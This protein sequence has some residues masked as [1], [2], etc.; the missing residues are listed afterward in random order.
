[1]GTTRKFLRNMDKVSLSN[2]GKATKL[3]K[4]VSA[5]TAMGFVLQPVAAMAQ[6]VTDIKPVN[7]GANVETNGKVT[8]VWA[9][10]VVN[11][12]ALN[13]FKKFDVG[14]ND[15]ANMYFHEQGKTAEANNLVNM[16]GSKININGTVNAI[17]NSKI[18][19]NLYFLSSNGIAVGAG[20]VVN[21]GSL[22][23]MTP[24]DRFMKTAMAAAGTDGV[25]TDATNA[26]INIFDDNYKVDVDTFKN[27]YLL[28][29][30]NRFQNMEVAINKTGTITVNGKINTTDG[31]RMKAAHINI[32][33]DVDA[34]D[35]ATNNSAAQAVLQSGV[36][37]FD[38]LVNLTAEQKRDAGLDG[39][40]TAAVSGDGNIVLTAVANSVNTKDDYAGFMSQNVQGYNSAQATIDIGNAEIKAVT[41]TPAKDGAPVGTIDIS[42]TATLG[43]DNG[44]FLG[45]DIIDTNLAEILGGKISKADAKI[46]ID[47]KLTADTIN[48]AANA[49]NSYE[50]EAT[51]NVGTLKDYAKDGIK[52]LIPGIDGIEDALG[53]E[54]DVSY[55]KLASNAEVT[56]GE[57]AEL[58]ATGNGTLEA[59]PNEDN[60]DSGL[61]EGGALNISAIS[62]LQ[63][64][65]GASSEQEP[66][67][68][69]GNAKAAGRANKQK[70]KNT[71]AKATPNAGIAIV[72]TQNNATV[73]VKGKL[74]AEKGDANVLASAVNNVEA[75]AGVT[76]VADKAEGTDSNYV[77]AAVTIANV[78]NAS[79]VEFAGDKVEAKA[80]GELNVLANAKNEVTTGASAGSDK[81]AL[82]NSAINITDANSSAD[83]IVAGK[84]EANKMNLAANNTVSNEMQAANKLGESK[85]E[86]KS[87]MGQGTL[88][89]FFGHASKKNKKGDKV[90]SIGNYFSAGAAVNI[91]EETNSA[92]V[93]IKRGAQLTA[94]GLE[95]TDKDGN[96]VPNL[97]ISANNVIEDSFM[98]ATSV[99][100]NYTG[101]KGNSSSSG[102]VS[103]GSSGGN[104][105]AMA[106]AAVLD[107]DMDN[108]AQVIIEGSDQGTS[109]PQI[110]GTHVDISAN[111]GF[112]YDRLGSMIDGLKDDYK[113]IID[114]YK[115]SLDGIAEW[116]TALDRVDKY[117][118]NPS[119]DGAMDVAEA[120]Q[121]A[122]DAITLAYVDTVTGVPEDLQTLVE[123]LLKFADISNYTNFYTAAS[124]AGGNALGGKAGGSGSSGQAKLAAT[125][126]INLNSIKNN[127]QVVIGKGAQLEAK[128]KNAKN[129]DVGELNITAKAKQHD[130]ALN[131]KT[132]Y[133]IPTIS[134]TSGGAT[135][136]GG[137][138]GVHDADVNSLIAIGEGASLTAN[139][140]NLKAEN[141]LQHTAITFGGGA[142]T[143]DGI[144]G[145]F[146]YMEGQSNSII[147]VDDEASINAANKL[148][149]D[150]TNNSTISNI[151]FD[152]TSAG[153]S[154]I[155]AA[156][157][158]IDYKVNNI[159][160]VADNDRDAARG[161]D[162]EVS[163]LQTLVQGQLSEE[164]K[165]QLGT[166]A[167]SAGKGTDNKGT[168]T[169]NEVDINAKT[170]GTITGVSVAGV[171]AGA[172]QKNNK[173]T[174]TGFKLP[175]KIAGAGSASVNTISGNT[176]ALLEG[177]EVATTGTNGNVSV[178]AKDE[179]MIGAYSGAA[180]LKK[181]GKQSS[182][183]GFSATLAG[184]IAYN[185][186]KTGVTA[187]I[188]DAAIK[189]A[190]KIS[191][192]AAREGAVVAAG[193]ALGVDTTGQGGGSS[194]TTIN[195]GV[196]ASI[197]EIDNST[198]AVMNNVTTSI[199]GG[200][201]T[202]PA[203]TDI[204]NIAQ[205]KDI[206]IAGGITAQYA[207]GGGIGI[208][209]AVSSLD[210]KNDI[211]SKIIG[212][213]SRLANVGELKAYAASDLVQVGTVLSAGVIQGQNGNAVEAAVANNQLENNVNVTI[214]GGSI[215]AN[216]IDAK[217]YDG[218]IQATTTH[219]KDLSDD[220][221]ETD[222]KD[223]MDEIN[224]VDENGKTHGTN[225]SIEKNKLGESKKDDAGNEQG[226]EG[227]EVKD[228]TADS[229]KGN[230]IISGAASI[231]ANTSTQGKV[232][233]GAAVV[234][235][236]IKNNFTTNITGTTITADT[237]QANAES[238]TLMVGVAAGAAVSTGANAVA[239]LAGS[240][241]VIQLENNT[242]TTI[243]NATITAKELEA[244]ATTKSRLINVAGQ[245]SVS[246]G[247]AAA[248][249][250]TATNVLNNTT[251][252]YIYGSK[253]TGKDGNDNTKLTVEADNNSEA[254]AI[255]VG[256]A[257]Q[258]AQQGAAL[259]GDVAVNK[260]VN[261]TEAIIGKR[262]NGNGNGNII[263]NVDDIDIKAVDNTKLK[264]ISGGVTVST[265]NAGLGG[266]VAYNQ[267]GDASGKQGTVAKL[268]DTVIKTDKATTI[269]VNAEDTSKMLAIAVGAAVQTG[270]S[271]A[272]AQGSAATTI[273]HKNVEAAVSNVDIDKDED[274]HNASLNVNAKS[275]AEA[276]TSADVVAFSTAN[277]AGGA[278]VAVT[279]SQ[280]DTKA[281]ITGGSMNLKSGK[282]QA[283]SKVD[284]I[285]VGIGVAAATGQ[286]GSIAGNVAVNNIGN[287]TTASIDGA[288][289]NASGTIGVLAD[290]KEHIRNYAG[291]LAA[292]V[293]QGYAAGGLSTA[294]NVISGNT[295]ANVS[296]SNITAA[297]DDAG[298]DVTEYAKDSKNNKKLTGLVVNAD[299][300]HEI[301]NVVVTAGA[302]VTAEAAVAASG[303]VTV[304]TI[305]GS[306]VAGIEGTNV[307]SGASNSIANTADVSVRANDNTEIGSHV[308]SAAVA[309]SANAGVSVG[310]A[311]DSNVMNRE[312][313]AQIVGDSSKNT[314]NADKLTVNAFNKHDI[315][316]NAIGIAGAG[317]AYAGVGVSGTTSVL[318]TT[319]KTTAQIAN[320]NSTNN[321][322]TIN[323]DH[324]N[325]VQMFGNS[326]VMSGAIGGVSVGT[327][328]AVL[329]DGSK[330]EAK[331]SG[332]AIKHYS[333]NYAV[334][335][336]TAKNDTDV[337]SE[338]ANAA[339]SASIGAGVS[340][341]ITVNN[342]DNAVYT[343]IETSTIGEENGKKAQSI[344]AKADN[345]LK[346]AFASGTGSVGLGAAGVGVGVNTID[347]S[348]VTDVS[349][350]KLYAKDVT[351]L[352]DEDRD[353]SQTAVSV[354]VGG[355]GVNASVLVTNIG[356]T[357]SDKYG[358]DK[359]DAVN[360][361]G[362]DANGQELMKDGDKVNISNAYTNANKAIDNQN[363]V[364]GSDKQNT[365]DALGGSSGKNN[366]LG[367]SSNV[368]DADGN[369]ITV[370]TNSGLANDDLKNGATAG[371]GGIADAKGVKV[372]VTNATIK[373]SDKADVKADATTNANITVGS[374]TAASVAVGATVGIL[375]VKRNSGVNI[376][377]SSVTADTIDV[378]SNQNGTSAVKV[379]QG[380]LS[381]TA[382]NVVYS[383]VHLTGQNDINIKG[384]TLAGANGVNVATGDTST[385]KLETIGVSGALTSSANIF[386]VDG[387]NESSSTITVDKDDNNKNSELTSA[388]DN[389]NIE[390][391]HGD[392]TTTTMEANIIPVAV[393]G[394]ASGLGFNAKVEDNSKTTVSVGDNQKFTG[395]TIDIKAENNSVN[396]VSSVTVN[397][398]LG[399]AIGATGVQAKGNAGSELKV[400][401][402]NTFTADTV[403]LG[404]KANVINDAQIT[405]VGA[406]FG[407]FMVNWAT[408]SGGTDVKVDVGDNTYNAKIINIKGE[409]V[410][411]QHA[412]ATGAIAGMYTSGTNLAKVDSNEKVEVKAGGNNAK[413]SNAAKNEVHITAEG[414]IK[415][416]AESNG[417]GGAYVDVSPA[418]AITKSN[419]TSNTKAIVTGN[420]NAKTMNVNAL[421]DNQ[422]K[423]D[424]DALKAA[425]VG[426][427]GVWA[428]SEVTNNTNVTLDGAQITTDNDVNVKAQNDITYTN[429]LLGGGYG[430][431]TGNA[432]DAKDTFTLNTGVTLKNNSSVTSENG[433]IA[434]SAI[435]GDGI[436][437][438]ATSRPKADITKNVKLQ[439]AGLVAGSL[440]FSR[441]TV[442]I[443]NAITV[444][445]GSALATKGNSLKKDANNISLIAV[446][447]LGFSDVT[448]ADTQGGAVGAASSDLKAEFDRQNTI[449][450]NGTIDSNY[451]AELNAG[452]NSV[453]NV[454][455]KSNAYNK[456][457]APIVA[458]PALDYTMKQANT[459]TIGSNDDN[460]TVQTARNINIIA[461]AGN[462]TIA[463]ET[464]SWKWTDGGET[465]TGSISSTAD[466][467]QNKNYELDNGV[468]VDGKLLAGKNSK[469]DITIDSSDAQKNNLKDAIN[470]Y[471]EA[472]NLDTLK[473]DVE[474]AEKKYNA[475]KD[476][477]SLKEKQEELSAKEETFNNNSNVYKQ[478]SE[479][480]NRLND[481]VKDA[482]EAKEQANS[483]YKTWITAE[484]A[485]YNNGKEENAKID[486]DAFVKL[487]TDSTTTEYGQYYSFY[488]DYNKKISQAETTLTTITAKRD[489]KN[490][491]MSGYNTAALAK[492][493]KGLK[494]DIEGLK[495]KIS[496][497]QV[498]KDLET[499]KT[500]YNKAV[501]QGID[502]GTVN[503]KIFNGKENNYLTVTAPDWFKQQYGDAYKNIGMDDYA[504]ALLNRLDELAKIM[505]SYKGTETSDKYST[506]LG[507]IQSELVALGLAYKDT[508]TGNFLIAENASTVPTIELKDLTVSGGNIDITGGYLK[509]SDTGKMTAVG[510]AQIYIENKTDFF[511]K[512]NDVTIDDAG[513]NIKFNDSSITTGKYGNIDVDA[514]PSKA[515]GSNAK[516][517]IKNTTST[518]ASES[519]IFTPDIGIFGNIYNPYGI[520]EITNDK[521]SIYVA[522]Q[523]KNTDGTIKQQ[524]GSIKGRSITLTAG[525]AITQGYTDGIVDIAGT[526]KDS[527]NK[528]Y[529]KAIQKA[530][531]DKV[532]DKNAS[533]KYYTS[534][535][536]INELIEF[537]KTITINVDGQD[538]HPNDTEAKTAAEAL[539]G[540]IATENNGIAA[541][542]A[543]YINAASI[544]VNGTIQSGASEYNIVFNNNDI[545]KLQAQ[546]GA[547]GKDITDDS[548]YKND[549][550]RISS[551]NGFV[552]NQDTGKYE[553][554]VE[555]WYNPATETIFTE[556][557]EQS[558]GGRI[559]LNG[560]IANTNKGGGKL[561]AL[562]GGANINIDTSSKG[563]NLKLGKI[564]ADKVEGMI[565]I[566]DTNTGKTTVY[567]RGSKTVDGVASNDDLTSYKPD[568]GLYYNWT[569]GESSQVISSYEHTTDSSWFGLSKDEWKDQISSVDSVTKDSWKQGNDVV[570]NGEQADQSSVINKGDVNGDYVAVAGSDDSKNR[571]IYQITFERSN[572]RKQGKDSNGKEL[573]WKTEDGQDVLTT[574]PTDRPYYLKDE[575]NN[576]IY[577][578]EV[579]DRVTTTHK[580][581]LFGLWGKTVTTKWKETKGMLTAYNFG[582]KADNS[583]GIEFIGN[584]DGS[585]LNVTANKDILL[586]GDIRANDVTITSQNGSINTA[587][588]DD[589]LKQTTIFTDNLKLNAKQDITALQQSVGKA[590]HLTAVAGRN[591]NIKAMAGITD[592]S[593]AANSNDASGNV[594]LDY[595]GA[596]NDLT[597]ELEGSV[598]NGTL[599]S[600]VTK[601]A[602]KS[603]NSAND[604][605]PANHVSYKGKLQLKAQGSIG[606]ADN[607]LDIADG[608]GSVNITT[609]SGNIYLKQAGNQAMKLNQVI[610]ENGDVF[611]DAD[612]GFI[613][614]IENNAKLSAS[615]A[616][617][618]AEWEKQGILGGTQ[619]PEQ[620][621]EEKVSYLEAQANSTGLLGDNFKD[622]GGLQAAGAE[623]VQAGKDLTDKIKSD[624]NAYY[625]ARKDMYAKQSALN[626]AISAK[627]K[628]TGTDEA[629]NAALSAYND[630]F[631]KYALAKKT[632]E[633]KKASA[634][635]DYVT[636]KGYTDTAGAKQNLKQKTNVSQWLA[637]Y[638][639]LTHLA[640]GE[641]IDAKYGWTEN[642]LLYAI[643]DSIINPSAGSVADVNNANII[644]NNITLKTEKGSLGNVDDTQKTV[645]SKADMSKM[646]DGT[647]MSDEFMNK[648]DKLAGARADDVTWGTD[649]IIV[650]RTTPISVKLNKNNGTE[651]TVTIDAPNSKNIYLIAKDSK[652]NIDKVISEGDVRLTGQKGIDINTIIGSN[653]S[654]EGGSGNIGSSERAERD[655]LAGLVGANANGKINANAAG[656]IWLTQL[657]NNNLPTGVTV[658]NDTE[659]K[660]DMVLGSLAAKNITINATRNIVSG[661]DKILDANGNTSEASGISYINASETLTLKT[662]GSVGSADSGL[663]VKNSGG[664][665]DIS[666]KNGAY[667]EAKGDGTLVLGKITTGSD[668]SDDFVVNSEGSLSVG[669]EEVK[670]S[671]GHTVISK[672]DGSINADAGDA[673]ANVKLTTA[674][675][676]TFRGKVRADEL[677]TQSYAGNIKQTT[678]EQTD[679]I[680][681]NKLNV[682]A[683][684]GDIKLANPYNV[685]KD[686]DIQGLGGNLE[687]VVSMDNLNLKLGSDSNA[688]S[689]NYG[690]DFKIT[691]NNGNINVKAAN[692]NIYGDIELNAV[693]DITV[694][695]DANDTISKLELNTNK[696]NDDNSNEALLQD[697]GNITLT[698]GE[699]ITNAG[700]IT[701]NA[702]N[703]TDAEGNVVAGEA[704]ITF[705]AK[706]VTNENALDAKTT[707]DINAT[708]GDITNNSTITADNDVDLN[709]SG[710]VENN[711]AITAEN[712]A[713]LNAGTSIESTANGTITSNNDTKLNAGTDITVGGAI[714]AT[715]D[716][717]LNA[718]NN[719][720]VN[721][722]IT[723]TNGNVEATTTNG[724]VTIN[725][726][727]KSGAD[728]TANAGTNGSVKVTDAGSINSTGDTSLKANGT[729]VIE[730]KG[731]I[732]AAGSIS[733]TTAN[734]SITI[735]AAMKSTEGGI[736]LNSN[737][738]NEG[739]QADITING[740]LQSDNGNIETTTKQGDVNFNGNVNVAKGDVTNNVGTGNVGFNA[741]TSIKEGNIKNTVGT[742][743]VKFNEKT[744]ITT[745]SI[746]NDVTTGNV[747]FNKETKVGTGDVTNNVGTG[748]VKFNGK[749]DITTG[750]ISNNVGTGNVDINGAANV[751]TGNISTTVDNGNIN[752]NAETNVNT[753]DI[754]TDA[755]NGNIS[756]NGNMTVDNGNISDKASGTITSPRHDEDATKPEVKLESINGSVNMETTGNGDINIYEVIANNGTAD[757]QSKGG[758]IYLYKINGKEVILITRNDIDVKRISADKLTTKGDDITL[759]IDREEG[760]VIDE[761]VATNDININKA[762]G[763]LDIE[764]LAVENKAHFDVNGMTTTVWG[765]APERENSDSVYW[766]NVN[767]WKNSGDWMNLVFNEKQHIQ[768]SNG[769]LLR[770]RNYFYVY[771]QRFTA[772]DHLNQLLAE[773]KADEYDINFNPEVVHYF[774]HDLYDLDELEQQLEEHA[775][776]AKIVV[777][778]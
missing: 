622:A 432:M 676:L 297:G 614:V 211:Q 311:S 666:A 327:A 29:N 252:A 291:A 75:E 280:S 95:E 151:I 411:D 456:T 777:E 391:K 215:S 378:K 251:G 574:D 71:L 469:L 333:D 520:V 443:T 86:V 115:D 767:A 260:G 579:T 766:F 318:K 435:T 670:D 264:A 137:S 616:D 672:V 313:T 587:G 708:A 753:G 238:D 162:D 383:G 662:E 330:T 241:G 263:T 110:K 635:N 606:S 679:N 472:L 141:D 186:V 589:A 132:K 457:A 561:V 747:E 421:H 564:N 729:G 126:S 565:T 516:I 222:G 509:G 450:V 85:R 551:G 28:N 98:A 647:L 726:A 735:D 184:A 697:H 359:T 600:T 13:V 124:T 503:D 604:I 356:T 578:F 704:N 387:K 213:N 366:V 163:D 661:M 336:I 721:G 504:A 556:D 510:D 424:T 620:K 518:K 372:N 590:L 230:L 434:M 105:A 269:D 688:L 113:D 25:L 27:S 30:W 636:A 131:G 719:I 485:K 639:E 121:N 658:P 570:K 109:V 744:N 37:N 270:Q 16:V 392:G 158:I 174:D 652:L 3:Q 249:L 362:E 751:G 681:A 245:V 81:N 273:L 530:L 656:D 601:Y 168:I 648:M 720:N 437:N 64:E 279:N 402:N 495:T 309:A 189:N 89:K 631:A 522:G 208:G 170:S 685:I 226:D 326:A 200:D 500:I 602:A 547:N 365:V 46:S 638:E 772:V 404:A 197:N 99:I 562:D 167:V 655:V 678:K 416:K 610:A 60:E 354:G 49:E 701:A 246:K 97:A 123:D 686:I 35:K 17:H 312:V 680:E 257:A 438:N 153:N 51:T 758:N 114:G 487:I 106:S 452:G 119:V 740:T 409:S 133:F 54:V 196:S 745:G 700:T 24:S 342:M 385:A 413:N 554:Q 306:T 533:K 774:R 307:N 427:S 256:V 559:Y 155:G 771:N 736:K 397:A 47:G 183:G 298:I 353:I 707:V 67:E 190:A 538:R 448:T 615:D 302:A 694:K 101:G 563:Y 176:A 710:K 128:G 486:Q 193:L 161:Q 540:Q 691:N 471:G 725:N 654:L 475:D 26:V 20:G 451:D 12:V 294:V 571:G 545:S 727:V 543:V 644:A 773:N 45:I 111:S 711:A 204:D 347:T 403:N 369:V 321:G 433:R 349:H 80:G 388:N 293:G 544:N 225:V 360:E 738:S 677:T 394:M 653:I 508:T 572:K 577:D 261:N 628:G 199:S 406:G 634:I 684:A 637:S 511:L 316:S 244:K 323:A 127:A 209:A 431:V 712:D 596:G 130:V 754:F 395:K 621:Y 125:G 207:R 494:S 466:G 583:I 750:S 206:Q 611:L 88:D 41:G 575:N 398:A 746:T 501:D 657:T 335:V 287:N 717:K 555:A 288:T 364:V 462:T 669:R 568:S 272:A 709:A 236:K 351:L 234:N 536:S 217:A 173:G 166:K 134:N 345:K 1:M 741:E 259:N 375:N 682:S 423:L 512:V 618:K 603:A 537:I 235:Q 730:V 283:D 419:I 430:A 38:N 171:T 465:G 104:T 731:A 194:A 489:S 405:A 439:S 525:N 267:I 329:N 531:I 549:K 515:T 699:N 521:N 488:A 595:V 479:E 441:D 493:I 289:M 117:L 408:A 185:D 732:T 42:A 573:Y 79:K 122:A 31:I 290:S 461:D 165:A 277:F 665:V 428:F 417:Y 733:G 713:I 567:K 473:K 477:L 57:N 242:T 102:N 53:L 253:I 148:A 761:L 258:V 449:T 649:N 69:G 317:G 389:V 39:N 55:A 328:I 205:S 663:R 407:S 15:I 593:I 382:L 470:K 613:D 703:T 350:S 769:A 401:N 282:V 337:L 702:A 367:S 91:V 43:G 112:E 331:L 227:K 484:L 557:I 11:D 73:I 276:I 560:A 358:V 178:S 224:G 247:K 82:L 630:A 50:E 18:G 502:K 474:E 460:N 19:G 532:S 233:A 139:D 393:A 507:R 6:I 368:K 668:A 284:I 667:L 693:K 625:T 586:A 87:K 629:Y 539:T 467:T 548:A 310:E 671:E 458:N 541:A 314:V 642:Q 303:T 187:Q 188:K 705:N 301:D 172:S 182:A 714:T 517:T 542:G 296:G 381:G 281:S 216:K 715:N 286:G 129:E 10:T 737:N 341:V 724:D 695:R 528:D 426:L 390:A 210:A 334:D 580:K 566:N 374:G 94:K 78:N 343:T 107:A 248:G 250:A 376:T 370:T 646:F 118:Q 770:L 180:A 338:A 463:A 498:S 598:L 58:K 295:S 760:M 308:G 399:A 756:H 444:E 605:A 229:N 674:N 420:W 142:A 265:G 422:V 459:V 135:A 83:L 212:D 7:G 764:K 626:K 584:T 526:P 191:N 2:L 319:A 384:A 315:L 100:N 292:T 689:N 285:N 513:G 300:A 599:P 558:G 150:A 322:L 62:N 446:D 65:I 32:G 687:L 588:F 742:G 154:A 776:P 203:N 476:V 373:A 445:K 415:Q 120:F 84:L 425:V 66:G 61:R 643:Q 361:K 650:E 585:K 775:D 592:S 324:V 696:L 748:D 136:I 440:A 68:E 418:A 641:S 640:T 762:K 386:V 76:A 607:Y 332:S 156:I 175:A 690:G 192:V 483:N 743:N 202:V 239:N 371:R 481:K 198:H 734:G 108:S 63:A 169:A 414:L 612:S 506:E 645:I 660:S 96:I 278:A 243:E 627:N 514:T 179:S 274:K 722:E 221:F 346:T 778:A 363:K 757:I 752:F 546:K 44:H 325:K 266:A 304:N 195:T 149:L 447:M 380:G 569:N 534:F 299:S 33:K 728:T 480:K 40:L 455:L 623:L 624:Y 379:Y 177:V 271:G 609:A 492:E 496:S 157:G 706:S 478:L 90:D 673:K 633:D 400:G 619:T 763:S 201:N 519:D 396:K 9:G 218:E 21:A 499:A 144:T 594:Y 482:Q 739:E 220:G 524:A 138:V 591:I 410:I 632:Y 491:E 505:Q 36:V 59:E 348:V 231:I 550:Y 93:T 320:V 429:E 48:I 768:S 8:N 56:I 34:N 436:D 442:N 464:K 718:G 529:V 237:V 219:L 140:V 254:Y 723:A 103:S 497:S 617:R 659:L 675:D 160:A 576:W 759:N 214:S 553:Y 765:K 228:F 683:I 52:G 535:A 143:N 5:V 582:L 145:M 527:V 412:N 355:I 305:N 223:T 92:K 116:G 339:V 340:G 147:S 523:I 453:M 22:T 664:V 344:T 552:Y 490:T 152:R 262:E 164:E 70:N 4:V 72:D 232:T 698:A 692:T 23:L 651:G 255:A 14:A 357:V 240:A 716:T 77:N 608:S 581:G 275:T 74:L 749:T 755:K 352:A 468:V 454:T 159:A 181:K 146:A 377:D 268:T 597:L